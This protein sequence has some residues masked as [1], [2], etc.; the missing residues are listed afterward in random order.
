MSAVDGGYELLPYQVRLLFIGRV[1]GDD[2]AGTDQL[3]AGGG[4]HDVVV[5]AGD[6]ELEVVEFVD[7]VLVLDLGIGE[8]RHTSG[9]PVDGEVGLV[10][11]AA[12][13]Q[14]HEGELGDAPVV[15]GVR[16]VVDGRI[17][18]LPED[19][20]VFGHLFDEAVGVVRTEFPV[21]LPGQ[22]E[23]GDVV[24]LLHTDLDRG[25]VDVETEG[26]EDVVALHPPVAGGEVDERVS[27]GVSEVEVPG[28]IS[29]RVVDAENGLV[30]FGVEAVD[31]L[32]LPHLL[33]FFLDL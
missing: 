3:G 33:P 10:D 31:G 18:A 23:L 22:V 11:E 9:T 26:E 19:L 2:L 1:D 24:L 25:T 7:V 29:G 8:G 27:G 4:Y 16:L 12:V 21:L 30:G 14:L 13:E 32:L 20:E 17:H 5:G 6:L 15:G 28:C